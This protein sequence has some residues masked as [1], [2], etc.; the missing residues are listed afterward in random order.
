VTTPFEAAN[1]AIFE[2]ARAFRAVTGKQEKWTGALSE[3]ATRAIRDW[4]AFAGWRSV[5][6]IQLAEEPDVQLHGRSLELSVRAGEQ[7]RA[8][9]ACL[10][11]DAAK[12][13]DREAER[14]GMAALATRARLFA[15]QDLCDPATVD[16]ALDFA[17][18]IA[19]ASYDGTS[20]ATDDAAAGASLALTELAVL[21]ERRLRREKEVAAEG[22]LR[23]LGYLVAARGALFTGETAGGEVWVRARVVA[24]DG[25]A[26]LERLEGVDA[27]GAERWVALDAGNVTPRSLVYAIARLPLR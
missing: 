14:A 10:D 23:W 19:T 16:R 6:E 12:V 24:K 26:H 27:L 13:K 1:E 17:S 5:E 7:F 20:H 15:V 11:E 3:K 21:I 22:P 9:A 25:V 2:L 18:M 4:A 8:L